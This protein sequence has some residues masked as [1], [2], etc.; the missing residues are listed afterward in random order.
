MKTTHKYFQAH[1]PNIS[2]VKIAQFH[3]PFMAL[4]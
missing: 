3:A 1:E 2:N 4:K